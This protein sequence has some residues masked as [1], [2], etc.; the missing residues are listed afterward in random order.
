MEARTLGDL[1]KSSAAGLNTLIDLK[2][3]GGGEFDG[4]QVIVKELQID[5]VSRDLVHA[6]FFAVDLTETIHVS[7]PVHLVGSAFGVTMGGIVD[8]ALRALEIQC[9]PNAIPEEFQVDVSALDVGDAIHV[10]DMILPASIELL[11]DRDLPVVSVVAPVVV[12]EEVVEEE[13]DEDAVAEEGEAGEQ[14]PE[15]TEEPSAD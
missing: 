2:V 4:V 6:D 12:E 3:A 9:L 1:L 8:H 13:V 10:R 14:A 7:V 5:P 15:P 11:T